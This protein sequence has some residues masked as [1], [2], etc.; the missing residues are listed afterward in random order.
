ML[1]QAVF[2]GIIGKSNAHKGPITTKEDLLK[3][4]QNRDK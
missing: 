1:S 2:G 4:K 3:E